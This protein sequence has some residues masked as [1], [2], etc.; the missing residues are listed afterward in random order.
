MSKEF[1][2]APLTVN[3]ITVRPSW[4]WS[5]EY[6]AEISASM[7]QAVSGAL[8]LEE[9]ER[10]YVEWYAAQNGLTHEQARRKIMQGGAS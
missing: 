6:R 2:D 8:P 4:P 7:R 5:K 1:S 9:R 3:G 10:R